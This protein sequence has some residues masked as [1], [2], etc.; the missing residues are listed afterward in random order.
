MLSHDKN[1]HIV[2][3]IM[4]EGYQL[5]T[6]GAV[7]HILECPA[8]TARVRAFPNCTNDIPIEYGKNF[9]LKAFMDPVTKIIKTYSAPIKCDP[10]APAMFFIKDLW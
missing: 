4:G 2:K 6:A 7:A 10:K 8:V 5:I 1:D 9:T 3:E